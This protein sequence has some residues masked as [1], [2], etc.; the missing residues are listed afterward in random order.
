M[1]IL[2]YQILT[3]RLHVTHGP[4]MLFKTFTQ[5]ISAC[6]NEADSVWSSKLTTIV[7]KFHNHVNINQN[8]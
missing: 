1:I 8:I 2:V 7:Y 5:I 4:N 3:E 6:L